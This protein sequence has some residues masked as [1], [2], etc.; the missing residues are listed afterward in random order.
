[1]P[2]SCSET[3][4][5]RFAV[6]TRAGQGP[7]AALYIGSDTGRCFALID[8]RPS[9]EVEGTTGLVG[10]ANAMRFLTKEHLVLPGAPKG[11]V[12]RIIF[13]GNDRGCGFWQPSDVVFVALPH[14]EQCAGSGLFRGW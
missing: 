7:P 11:G 10:Y 3:T 8:L 1:M 14:W 9:I 2:I 12:P 4:G 5:R 13:D 6:H